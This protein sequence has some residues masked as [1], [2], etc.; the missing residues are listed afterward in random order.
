MELHILIVARIGGIRSADMVIR[1]CAVSIFVVPLLYADSSFTRDV[2]PVLKKNCAGCH[3]PA[4]KSSGLDLSTY[5]GLRKG[6]SKGAAFNAGQPEAS[7]II[8]FVT[9]E[10]KPPMPFG[11]SPLPAAEIAT[12]REWIK[13]GAKDDTPH[14]QTSN[15]PPVYHQPPV[16][17]ALRY[18]PDG[19]FLAVSGNREVLLNKADGSGI[20]KRLVGKS[21]RILAISFSADG[22]TMI[23]V[24]GNPA[25]FGEVQVWNP[26]DG[27][28]LRSIDVSSDTVFGGALSADGKQAVVGCT[29]NTVR[30]FDTANGKELYK[31]ASHENWPLAIVFGVDSKRVVSVGRDR[32]A[33]LIDASAG[34]FLENVNQLHTELSAVARHPKTDEIVVGGDDRIP[35]LYKMDRPRNMKVGEE[36]TLVRKLEPQDGAI[37][38]L[39]WSPDGKRIAVAGAGSSVNIYDAESGDRVAACKGHQAGIYAVAFSPDSANLAAG[40]FDGQVRLYRVA[41]CTLEKAFVPVPLEAAVAQGGAQ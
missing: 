6:G 34:Q 40:G 13:E 2:Q 9:G 25:R 35:Y 33:K 36:A 30:A 38:A 21:Q 31:I 10:M 17:T 41:D 15:E 12:L 1:L 5:E 18:S 14:E 26:A 7:L 20:A 37:F 22:R 4:M 27:K 39:D 8:K 28:L 19:K 24:G 11:G 23:A 29:D 3:Q 32:A 16:I